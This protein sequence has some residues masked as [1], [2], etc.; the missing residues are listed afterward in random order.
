MM[1]L[2]HQKRDSLLLVIPTHNRPNKLYRTLCFIAYQQGAILNEIDI[3]IID[4]SEGDN[5]KKNKNTV[6]NLKKEIRLTHHDY[7]GKDIY[8][9]FKDFMV[10]KLINLEGNFCIIGDDDFVNI[11]SLYDAHVFLSVNSSFSSA[12]G[13]I[14]TAS[15]EEHSIFNM[16]PYPQRELIQDDPRSRLLSHLRDPENNFYSVFSSKNLIK[17]Y[18]EINDLDI[19]RS[20]KERL[21]STAVIFSGKR[22]L[23]N[24]SF[25]VRDKSGKTGYDEAGNRTLNDNPESPDYIESITYNYDAYQA[26]LLSWIDS[27][28]DPHLLTSLLEDDYNR[29]ITT[30]MNVLSYPSRVIRKVR[31]M[32][33]GRILDRFA[34]DHFLIQVSRYVSARD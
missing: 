2:K 11:A 10:R 3:H 14:Y 31:M 7:S 15:I 9:K 6:E 28:I 23:L 20:L 18:L 32:L 33:Q 1:T 21:L 13:R 30:K 22:K 25:L 19:G 24:S 34:M 16:K 26:V 27:D 8:E 5:L 17:Y 4:S 12:N 29:F